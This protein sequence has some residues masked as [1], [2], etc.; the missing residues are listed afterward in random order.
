MQAKGHHWTI[1]L[2]LD[3]V[4]STATQ[5]ANEQADARL[6]MVTVFVA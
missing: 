2:L 1:R 4:V 5:W 3:E 6:R